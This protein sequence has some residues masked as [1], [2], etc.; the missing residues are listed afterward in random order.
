MSPKTFS[1]ARTA[2]RI[3]ITASSR[4][5]G[6]G[7]CCHRLRRPLLD[8]LFPEFA[9]GR[10]AESRER[11][12]TRVFPSAEEVSVAVARDIALPGLTREKVLACVLRIL[13]TCFLRPG[14]KIYAEENGS[15]GIATLRAKVEPDAGNPQ[16]LRTVHGVGY[17]L[18]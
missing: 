8:E 14:S 9:R 1:A 5:P 15:Y 13:S 16:Y 18:R 6:P 10:V 2:S 7:P 17:S 12:P 4:L 11:I 3:A